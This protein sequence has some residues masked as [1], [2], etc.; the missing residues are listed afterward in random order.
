M[1]CD[2]IV[3]NGMGV[4]LDYITFSIDIFLLSTLH[5]ILIFLYCFSF[6]F[7][8]AVYLIYNV[9]SGVKQSGPVTHT[10]IST[11]SFFFFKIIFPFRLSISQLFTFKILIPCK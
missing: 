2:C 10:C 8:I 7:F 3:G 5:F 11:L 1:I 9:I 4:Y 6:L